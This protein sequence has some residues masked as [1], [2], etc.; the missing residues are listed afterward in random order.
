M[1]VKKSNPDSIIIKFARILI[2]KSHE[3]NNIYSIDNGF[4]HQ[5]HDGS[6]K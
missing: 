6:T 5:L 1:I 4:E 2:I 3:K